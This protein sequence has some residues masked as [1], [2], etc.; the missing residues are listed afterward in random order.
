M[1]GAGE[2]GRGW[3]RYGEEGKVGWGGVGRIG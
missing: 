2:A 1:G 3:V